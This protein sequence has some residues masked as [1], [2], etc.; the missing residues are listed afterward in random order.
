MAA[1]VGGRVEV[2]GLRSSS[3]QGDVRFA[4]FLGRMGCTVLDGPEGLGVA[5]S[6]EVA[7]VGI[8]VDLADSSDL[9]PTLA[10]VAATASTATTITGVGFIRRKES[11]RLSDLATELNKAGGRVDVLADGLRISPSP[12]LHG[13]VLEP[14]DDHRLAMAFGVL[15]A[16]VSGIEVLDPAVV[17]KSWPEFWTMR[18]ALLSSA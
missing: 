2:P 15:G 16:A 13:A 1:V 8:E 12:R 10:A 6:R 5:R 9:V 18:D 4:D 7:L 14:H 11:D 3:P 17:A